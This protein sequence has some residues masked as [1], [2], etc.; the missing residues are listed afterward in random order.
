VVPA[1]SPG[2]GKGPSWIGLAAAHF[3]GEIVLAEDLD[4][5]EV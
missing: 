4:R 1:P 3:D 2:P 5:I